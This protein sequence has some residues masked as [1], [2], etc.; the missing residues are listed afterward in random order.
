MRE[1]V[2]RAGGEPLMIQAGTVR[3][4]HRPNPSAGVTLMPPT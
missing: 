4:N 3:P 2:A 1:A